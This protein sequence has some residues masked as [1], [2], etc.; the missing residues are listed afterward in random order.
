[1]Y[2]YIYKWS[3]TKEKYLKYKTKYENLL[4]EMKGGV[5]ASM[6]QG[7]AEANESNENEASHKFNGGMY[8]IFRGD[9]RVP[10][11]NMEVINEFDKAYLNQKTT[12][13]DIVIN[14][15]RYRVTGQRE[16]RELKDMTGD[17]NRQEMGDKI[18]YIDMRG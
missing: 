12:G 5:D 2:I 7:G 3:T 16:Y 1:M 14:N 4:R 10:F 18:K 13:S 8:V 17:S 11:V 15:V 6:A 9:W